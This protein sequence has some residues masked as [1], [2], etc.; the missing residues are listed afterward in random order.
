MIET[1]YKQIDPRNKWLILVIVLTVIGL[2]LRLYRLTFQSI[3]VDEAFTW[4]Y[5][6]N[7]WSQI[8]WLTPTDCHPPLFYWITKLFLLQGKSDFMLRLFPALIG[9]ATIPIFYY[10]GKTA[11]SEEVGV[12]MAA[13]LAFSPFHVAYSQEARMYTFWLFLF[14]IGFVFY[15]RERYG[16]FAVLSGLQLWAQFLSAISFVTLWILQKKERVCSL[17]IYSII[18]LPLVW[19][20]PLIFISKTNGQM[21]GYIGLPFVTQSFCEL[22]GYTIFQVLLLFI[23]I[24]FGAWF[25]YKKNLRLFLICFIFVVVVTVFTSALSFVMPTMPRYLIVLLTP[26]LL[27]AATA[28]R[29]TAVFRYIA[30]ILILLSCI[31]LVPQYTTMIKDDWRDIPPQFTNDTVAVVPE[32]EDIPLLYYFPDC[33]VNDEGIAKYVITTNEDYETERRLV[34][35]GKG[36]RIYE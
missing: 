24:V 15:L 6:Q 20:I 5:V 35:E 19:F 2:I 16:W 4:F 26:L 7:G 33:V 21:W 18:A 23:L 29:Y 22:L 8:F 17:V 10:I 27:F 25:L 14:A 9:T 30:V 11:D 36:I 28:P 34:W 1:L 32:F 31:G 13:F 12:W 3:W